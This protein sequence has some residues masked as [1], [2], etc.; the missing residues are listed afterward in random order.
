MKTRTQIINETLRIRAEI[1]QIH[2]DVRHWNDNVRKAHEQPIDWDPSGDMQRLHM[3][4]DEG[5][6][7]ELLCVHVAGP[8]EVEAVASL[9]A[10]DTRVLELNVAFGRTASDCWASIQ[11]WPGT[12]E[13]HA[14]ALDNK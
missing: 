2:D 13:E 4:I 9:A 8:D 6:K 14:K 5:L 3:G 10:A 12:P 11:A 7:K 1:E